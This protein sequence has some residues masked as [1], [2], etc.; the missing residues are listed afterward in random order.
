MQPSKYQGVTDQDLIKNRN[1]MKGVLIGFGIIYLVAL[2][3]LGYYLNKNGLKKVSLVALIPL[4]GMP[5]TLLP[6]FINFVS[7]QK[8]CKARNI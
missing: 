3:L 1:L 2:V 5:I 8:E 7:L 4:F 6:L